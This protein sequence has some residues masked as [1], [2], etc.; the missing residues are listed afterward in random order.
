MNRTYEVFEVRAEDLV[1]DE[2][3]GS[4]PKFWFS[5]GQERWLF[6]E[7]RENTGE[8]WA[9]KIA[10]EVAA[11]LG[12][13]AAKVELAEFAGRRG[14][15][16]RSFVDTSRGQSLIHGNEVLAGLVVKY[17]PA[18]RL[19]QSDHN[20]ENIYLAL[21]KLFDKSG[22]GPVLTQLAEYLVLD[23]LIGN[24]DRHHENWGLLLELPSEAST[25]PGGEVRDELSVAPTFDHASSL[26]RELLDPARARLIAEHRV[27][28]YVRRGHGGVYLKGTDRR[29]AN[30]LDLVEYGVTA[31]ADYFTPIL[32]RMHQTS[33][34]P[35]V[36]TVDGVPNIRMSVAAK[37]FA[38]EFIR[39]SHLALM[40]L[41]I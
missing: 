1:G 38:K 16:S 2:T 37:N 14:C 30:P 29:G 23:A 25:P 18:K 41:K 33:V 11:V 3:L 17:D 9:E 40:A 22:R 5:R 34:D 28:W 4:K 21:T 39:Q 13:P 26:G 24:T 19:R 8:D 32:R 15:A 6:K 12:I 10:A 35:L 27:A 36:D 31:Y 20:L 7:A